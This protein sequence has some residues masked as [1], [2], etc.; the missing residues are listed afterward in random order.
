MTELTEKPDEMEEFLKDIKKSIG[1]LGES[2]P[3]GTEETEQ[4]AAP[5]REP[6]G[7]AAP[8]EERL[9]EETPDAAAPEEDEEVWVPGKKTHTGLI[10]AATLVGILL[11]GAILALL[12]GVRYSVANKFFEKERYAIAG[13]IYSTIPGHKDSDE[14]LGEVREIL[15]EQAAERAYQEGLSLMAEKDYPAAAEAFGEAGAHKD[16]EKRRTF[17][18]LAQKSLELTFYRNDKADRNL[19]LE[20]DVLQ[21]RYNE[22][23]GKILV[24]EESVRAELDSL[25]EEVYTEKVDSSWTQESE[26]AN[27]NI[28]MGI[29]GVE[30][31]V[32]ATLKKIAKAA[33]N[34]DFSGLKAGYNISEC[35]KLNLDTIRRKVCTDPVNAEYDPETHHAREGKVGYTFNEDWATAAVTKTAPGETVIIPLTEVQPEYDADSLDRVYFSCVIGEYKTGELG[36]Y[37]RA[38]NITL[39]CEAVNGTILNPGE[40]FSFNDVVGER[41]FERGFR[42]A[43]AYS[44]GKSVQEIGGGI[45]QVSTTIYNSALLANLEIVTRTEHCYPSAYCPIGLDATV[46]WGGPHFAFRNNTDYP[47]RIDAKVEDGWCKVQLIGTDDGVHVEMTTE[48]TGVYPYETRTTTD[49]DEVNETGHTGYRVTSYRN[50]YDDKTGELLYSGVEAYSYYY[51]QDIV[52]LVEE[53][54]PEKP[55]P[56]EA[57]PEEADPGEETNPIP[58]TNPAD[59]EEED[60][61]PPPEA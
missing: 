21:L 55:E 1:D 16:A 36:S 38:T 14:R 22:A 7:E 59:P 49:P 46:S 52:K 58:D 47:I 28:T 57:D 34:A 24:N 60:E 53:E 54:K 10:V 45:C 20:P 48:T 5:E 33:E 8:E 11:V 43:G 32:D 40:T 51:R 13:T 61:T 27:V 25:A 31:D 44:G 4:E 39:A 12:P 19:L 35:K 56:S 26:G 41:T 29:D 30:L 42:A 17:C 15:A 6:A 50:V 18:E 37:N 9:G 23:D 3:E 2:E